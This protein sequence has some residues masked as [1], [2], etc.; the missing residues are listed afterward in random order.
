MADITDPNFVKWVQEVVRPNA[1]TI[2]NMHAELTNSDADWVATIVSRDGG[3][4][5]GLKPELTVTELQ[6]HLELRDFELIHAGRIL[7]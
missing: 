6:S 7:E 1:E 2:R 4:A 3:S 5:A